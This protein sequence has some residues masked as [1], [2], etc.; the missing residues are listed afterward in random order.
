[1]KCTVDHRTTRRLARF[2]AGSI[3]DQLH[4]EHESFASDVAD[5]RVSRLQFAQTFHKISADLRS[6]GGVLAFDQVECDER[7]RATE[8][9]TA[10]SVRM[11]AA[12]PLLHDPFFG[13]DQTD[14]Q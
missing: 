12:F 4:T 3:A 14:R 1:M 13:N 8:R 6:V 10:K 11:R 9:I 7:R 5:N 2:A